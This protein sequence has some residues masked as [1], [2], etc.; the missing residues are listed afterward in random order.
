MIR[1]GG[2]TKGETTK[3]GGSLVFGKD[4]SPPKPI[5]ARVG[6]TLHR[7]ATA[8]EPYKRRGVKGRKP[9]DIRIGSKVEPIEKVDGY[10]VSKSSSE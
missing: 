7:G 1:V 6:I 10:F 2:G 5:G 9:K 3:P 4:H 8:L